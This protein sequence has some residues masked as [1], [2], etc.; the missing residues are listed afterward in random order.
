VHYKKETGVHISQDEKNGTWTS[1]AGETLVE[2]SQGKRPFARLKS[3][4]EDN[5]KIDVR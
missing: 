3:R 2:E 5:I 4:W 1:H